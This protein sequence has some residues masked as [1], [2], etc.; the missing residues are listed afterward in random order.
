MVA[1][2]LAFRDALRQ[3]AALDRL[4]YSPLAWALLAAAVLLVSSLNGSSTSLQQW[5]GDTD[6]AVRLV[7]V[8]ELLAGGPWFDTTLSTIGA[9][10]PLVSHWSR[11]IDLPLALMM[12]ALALPLGPERAELVTRVLWPVLVFFALQ[13]IVTRE[14][15][16]RAGPWAA[17]FTI[18]FV[19]TAM[20]AV[21][22]FRPG[23][24]DHHNVQILCAVGGIL[25]LLRSLDEERVGWAAGALL[26]LGLAVGYEAVALVAPSLALAALLGL[27]QRR[28]LPGVIRAATAATIVMAAALVVTVP[29]W[30]WLDI[31]CDALALNVPVLAVCCTAGLAV[32][33]IAD[34]RFL[35][36]LA[37]VGAAAG[38]G[39]AAFG[40]LEPAC[41]AG[42][43]GQVDPALKSVWLDDVMETK[44]VLWLLAA[45]PTLAISF[46]ACMVAG[47]VAQVM[48]WRAERDAPSAL[49]LAMVALAALLGCWQI[50]LMPYAMWLVV[51]PLA[52]ACARLEGI[53]SIS[54]PVVRLAAAVLLTQA[55]FEMVAS[56]VVTPLQ[57]A[58]QSASANAPELIGD[59]HRACFRNDAVRE[60][61]ALPAGL[62]AGDIDLGPFIAANSSH[63]VVA[64]PYHRLSK[65]ILANHAILTGPIDEAVREVARLGV[66]YVVLCADG[67]AP[68]SD[69]VSL[70]GRLLRGEQVPFMTPVTLGGTTAL[71]AWRVVTAR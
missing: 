44:S 48:I 28:Y 36:R 8:R 54:A 23:R 46:A 7:T 39:V 2:V 49:G 33:L 32:A 42:P 43:F 24:V 40:A 12:K 9:P 16:R 14:A 56:A 51:V 6:D 18:V 13:A 26:G 65:G 31:H 59:P 58:G 35:A 52:V 15:W 55:T 53:C 60:L 41:L 20:T 61:A 25:L 21:A 27:W 11:L 69:D 45:R 37:I 62:V 68:A 63:R 34:V 4:F 1:P 38:V 57:A 47:L 50:K 17:A 30:R 67:K 5:L 71:R 3:P 22:Q 70:R 19:V 66:G 10:E 29:P 64:A